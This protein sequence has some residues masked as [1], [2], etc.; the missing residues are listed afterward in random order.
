MADDPLQR[1]SGKDAGVSVID[2][3]AKKKLA[4]IKLGGDPYGVAVKK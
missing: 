3:N 1:L 4:T 2:I